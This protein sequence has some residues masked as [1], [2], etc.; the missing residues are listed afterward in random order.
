MDFVTALPVSPEKKRL[1]DGWM[2]WQAEIR[3][4]QLAIANTG[5]L[6]EAP[7]ASG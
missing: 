7:S 6:I 4:R 2:E 1:Q 5:S 3:E